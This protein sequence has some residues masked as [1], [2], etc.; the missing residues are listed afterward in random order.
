[1]FSEGL[2]YE[3]GQVGDTFFNPGLYNER[4]KIDFASP[5]FLTTPTFL[6]FL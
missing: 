1:M 2:F 4:K 3:I 5:D 6:W